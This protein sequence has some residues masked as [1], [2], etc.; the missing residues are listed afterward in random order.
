[1]INL[2]RVKMFHNPTI[3][4]FLVDL[5]FSEC[6]L[7]VVIFD[8]ITP[9]IIKRVNLAGNLPT[10]LNIKSLINLREASLSQH[11]QD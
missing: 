8:L 9:A 3:L 7:D 2:N 10:H 11:R 6:V 5:I 4:K 1:M